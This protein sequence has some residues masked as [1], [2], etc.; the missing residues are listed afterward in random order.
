MNEKLVIGH[1]TGTGGSK[2]ILATTRGEIIATEFEP[3]V[4]CHPG[5]HCAEQDPADWW[6]AVS[7]T[8]RRLLEKTGTEPA[9][10]AGIAFATQMLGVLPVGAD[11]EPL[12]D[13]MIWMDCRAQEQ[14]ARIVRRMGG[15]R[16]V[17]ALFGAVPSGKDVMCKIKWVKEREPD[18]YER[19]RAFLDVK[20]YLVLRATGKFLT[21]QTAASVTGL[22]G[23]KT[24]DWSALPA[25][26]LG[27]PLDKLP[28]VQSS[29]EVAGELTEA[30]AADMGLLAGTPVVAGMGDAPAGAIG[31]GS[32]DH[33]EAVISIGTSGLLLITVSKTINL[34]KFGMASIAAASPDKWLLV[35]ETNTAGECLRWFADTLSSEAERARAGAGGG[36]YRVLDD[37]AGRVPPGSNRLVFTPWMYG[38][39]APVTDSTL[40]GAFTNVSLEHTR[41]DMLRAVYEGVAMNFAWMLEAAEGKGL[42]CRT[43]RVIGGGALSD[44][45]MQIFADVTGRRM[46]AMEGA[47]E[48]GALGAALAVP[49]ALG[50][51]SD[52]SEVKKVVKVRRTFEPDPANRALY[53]EI[54]DAFKKLYSRLSPVYRS[55]NR[56]QEP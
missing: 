17:M 19:T 3:Y 30:A 32:L 37:V 6:R 1:D 26:L 8:T 53:D 27:V 2:A 54:F 7:V 5:P 34:G 49:V 21:D 52:Y 55:L 20:A 24:R 47:Q 16:V 38:E 12:R 31:A 48:A 42:P 10:I 4:V 46:E 23:K 44:P 36:I 13:A 51:Y 56:A 45:W 43:V 39:R 41:V 11:G 40:R 22:M 28:E 14:A 25:K 50:I 9:S 18:I 15:Q 29:V 35:G 33:G